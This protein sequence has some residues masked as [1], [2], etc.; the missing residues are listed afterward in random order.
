[1]LQVQ[2][3]QIR[4]GRALILTDF[5]WQHRPGEVAWVVGE[6]GAGKS[7]LLRILA[8]REQPVSGS[9]QRAGPSGEPPGLIYYHPGMAL[10][11]QMT[12]RDW[13]RFTENVVPAGARYPLDPALLPATILPHKRVE[14]LSTGEAKRL[15]LAALL[16]RDA[17]F[18][19][20]DEP[21]E[22][23]SRE[24]KELLAA[25]LGERAM[26]RVVVV[27]TNQEIPAGAAGQALRYEGNQMMTTSGGEV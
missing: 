2:R 24:G 19:I 23:L 10:P 22:H 13:I 3:L 17:P 14:Q 6:N 20:H 21:F 18:I 9:V 12:V 1:M 4:K 7:S 15:A 26:T 8:G 5:T 27:A 11:A 16:S 25:H